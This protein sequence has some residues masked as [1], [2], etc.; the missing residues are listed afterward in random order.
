MRTKQAS[1]LFASPEQ[2]APPWD[3]AGLLHKR[4]RTLLPLPHVLLQADQAPQ[5]DQFPATR[6]NEGEQYEKYKKK[7]HNEEGD[8]RH[9][10]TLSFLID[11]ELTTLHHLCIVTLYFQALNSK[12]SSY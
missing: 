9:A 5:E 7:V 10:W 4:D 11:P 6:D 8:L 2:N 3:G 12:I 1:V